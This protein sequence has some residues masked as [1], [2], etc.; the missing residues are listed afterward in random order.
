MILIEAMY[1]QIMKPKVY[2][3]TSVISYLAWRPSRDLIMA[4]HQQVTQEWW[5]KQ[6]FVLRLS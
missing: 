3:E 2:I 6:R 1:N 5:E 4:A